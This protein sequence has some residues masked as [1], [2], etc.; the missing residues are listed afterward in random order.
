MEKQHG[1]HRFWTTSVA[2]RD[3]GFVGLQLHQATPQCTDCVAEVTFWDAS[4]QFYIKT[5]GEIPL[6][7]MEALIAEAKD[8]IRTG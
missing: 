1:N 3:K 6:S 2:D 8:T 7:V 5:S 4:G